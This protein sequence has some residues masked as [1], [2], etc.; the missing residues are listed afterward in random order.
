M[1]KL[2]TLPAILLLSFSIMLGQITTQEDPISFRMVIPVS[3]NMN[4][5]TQ[6]KMPAIDLARILKEDMEEEE[7]GFPPRFGYKHRVN[8]TLEN[9]GEWIT[10]PNGSRLWQ[11]TISSPGALSINLLYDKFWLPDGAKLWTYSND[12]KHT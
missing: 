4:E 2:I 7:L 8:Y 9:S 5:R 11:L 1:K 3:F 6:K 10:L 12:H